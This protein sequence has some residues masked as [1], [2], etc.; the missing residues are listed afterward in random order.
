[1]G[2]FLDGLDKSKL[3]GAIN[4]VKS[5]IGEKE[6]KKIEAASKNEKEL[7]KL[8]DGLSDKEKNAILKVMSDPQMLSMVLSSAK[9]REGIKKFLN[10]R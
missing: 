4:L 5:T 6:S 9:A 3:D 10:E 2:N 1:M 8:L 7:E